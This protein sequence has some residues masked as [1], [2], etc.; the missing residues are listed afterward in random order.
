MIIEKLNKMS[1]K[2]VRITFAQVAEDGSGIFL[3]I[4]DEQNPTVAREGRFVP[5]DSWGRIPSD[6]D[7]KKELQVIADLF[8]GVRREG[9]N[10]VP[11][12]G[13]EQRYI[14]LE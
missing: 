8:N 9:K 11:I 14:T 1:K 12:E 4:S 6:K 7:P 2:K 10:L 5:A 3:F 13:W